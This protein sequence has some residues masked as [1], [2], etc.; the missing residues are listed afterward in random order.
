LCKICDSRQKK[1]R[2][3]IIEPEGDD[4]QIKHDTEQNLV[5]SDMLTSSGMAEAHAPTACSPISSLKS[6]W[7]HQ[8]HSSLE[9][10]ENLQER[11]SVVYNIFHLCSKLLEYLHEIG[12][13]NMGLFTVVTSNS[14]R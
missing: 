2:I 6:L 5:K 14:F 7:I 13:D 9:R 12:P 11:D 1:Q 10:I 8:K 3:N 4:L